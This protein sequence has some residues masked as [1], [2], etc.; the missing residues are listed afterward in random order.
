MLENGVSVMPEPDG[1]FPQVSG[2][3]FTYDISAQAGS[4]VTGAVRQA[5]DGS[6]TGEAVDLSAAATYSLATNDFM[7]SGG[8]D[9]PDF[10]SRMTTL[11][12]MDEV[13]AD[14]IVANTPVSPAIQSRIVCTPEGHPDCP[15]V[16][17]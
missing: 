16:A 11:E 9:Y 8:D 6:C 3:C 15:V 13:L 1:R 4:R 17:P 2:L 12:L 14:Y 5:D 7:A 10:S